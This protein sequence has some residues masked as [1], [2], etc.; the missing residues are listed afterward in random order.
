MGGVFV[1]AL[2]SLIGVWAAAA[3]RTLGV[4]RAG[5]HRDR[6]AAVLWLAVRGLPADRCEWGQ[7]MLGELAE[8]QGSRARWRF[9]LGCARAAVTLRIRDRF[10]GGHRDGVLARAVVL[11]AATAALALS[12]FG[13]IRYS[14]L[15]S[16]GAWAGV[17]IL[18]AALLGYVV[19][20]L[21][22]SRG[23]TP[24]AVLA[25]RYGLLGGLPVGAAWI[26]AIF[27]TAPL[28][29]WVLAPLLIAMLGP[30]SVAALTRRSTGDA[31]AATAAAMWCG[32]VGG[33]VV[34]VTWVS[35]TYLLQGR[36]LDPQ[37]I[38]DFH[39]SGAPNLTAY[40][41]SDNVGTAV[42]MLAITPIIALAA[43]SLAA[44][45]STKPTAKPHTD[46]A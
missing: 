6:P 11:G 8:A 38:R 20:A 17:L 7:A 1:I 36:P 37:L 35:A 34:F 43:G 21:G 39:A 27:P 19:C 45:I 23:T 18:L 14:L 40:A 28:K 15:R 12:G 13:L 30:A 31:K 42:G 29:Q 3:V 26:V 25:R 44:R 4:L 2:V 22:L 46:T 9:S 10:G 16:P 41:V 33:L 5:D 24:R 32:L